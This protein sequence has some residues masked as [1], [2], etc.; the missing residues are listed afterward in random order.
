MENACEPR[1]DGGSLAHFT[2]TS[3]SH[4]KIV[5]GSPEAI[6]DFLKTDYYVS[7]DGL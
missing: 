1:V 3:L 2:G 7:K 6:T 5:V 4:P